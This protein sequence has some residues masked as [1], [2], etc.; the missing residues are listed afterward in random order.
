MAAVQPAGPLP[1]ITTRRRYHMAPS[2]ENDALRAE[3]KP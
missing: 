1:M 3:V 2:S